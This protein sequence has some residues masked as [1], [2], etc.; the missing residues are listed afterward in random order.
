[1][2]T[3]RFGQNAKRVV[4][5]ASVNESVTDKALLARKDEEIKALMA[6]VQE[7][8]GQRLRGTPSGRGLHTPVLAR[9]AMT[10]GAGGE[11]RRGTWVEKF[12]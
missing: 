9:H 1:M 10:R 8:E 7:L 4:N 12:Y 6:K 5:H 3:L 11:A 2:D